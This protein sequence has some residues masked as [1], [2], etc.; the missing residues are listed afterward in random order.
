MLHGPGASFAQI[1]NVPSLTFRQLE[2]P[3]LLV[4]GVMVAIPMAF[5]ACLHSVLGKP[6]P[7]YLTCRTPKTTQIAYDSVGSTTS[8]PLG[9]LVAGWAVI[10]MGYV[11]LFL[12]SLLLPPHHRSP[13]Q[14]VY[15]V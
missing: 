9:F 11:Y 13:L 10:V 14:E 2:L 6:N 1:V 15:A 7:R 4:I 12:R 8:L 5:T 3:G